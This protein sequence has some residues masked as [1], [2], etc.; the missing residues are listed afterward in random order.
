M[1]PNYINCETRLQWLD[2]GGK[3]GSK[4]LKQA[5]I[6]AQK[7]FIKSFKPL[8]KQI[9]SHTLNSRSHPDLFIKKAMSLSGFEPQTLL[10]KIKSLPLSHE[11][12]QDYW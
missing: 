3:F 8:Y 5:L 7:A 11:P 4:R 9:D 1:K 10:H 6:F 2:S 12:I